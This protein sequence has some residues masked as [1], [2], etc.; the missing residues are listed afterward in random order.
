VLPRCVIAEFFLPELRC[1]QDPLISGTSPTAATSLVD[2]IAGKA[3]FRFAVEQVRKECDVV[4]PMVEALIN[5][6]AESLQ[7]VD[8]HTR[9]LRQQLFVLLQNF[10]RSFVPLGPIAP[11]T[12]AR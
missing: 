11:F 10:G 7:L 1:V 6:K 12:E 9:R 3:L 5:K 8:H 4:Q 2:D